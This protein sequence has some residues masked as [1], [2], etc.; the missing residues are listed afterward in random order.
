[1][2]DARSLARSSFHYDMYP[3]NSRRD[4]LKKSSPFDGEENPN[5]FVWSTLE[6]NVLGDNEYAYRNAPGMSDV[7][8]FTVTW[9]RAE[10]RSV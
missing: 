10:T 3:V 1:M 6:R 2:D 9:Y 7:G 8:R 4:V 5:S